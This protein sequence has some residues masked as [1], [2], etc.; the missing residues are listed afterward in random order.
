MIPSGTQTLEAVS[1]HIRLLSAERKIYTMGRSKKRKRVWKC[2]SLVDQ[3]KRMTVCEP[4]RSTEAFTW[5]LSRW[6]RDSRP[7]QLS[8]GSCHV[9]ERW[10]WICRGEDPAIGSFLFLSVTLLVMLSVLSQGRNNISVTNNI[11]VK[12]APWGLWNIYL[13]VI[14]ITVSFFSCFSLW[15]Y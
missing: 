15:P 1:R 13:T 10:W 8:G 14:S 11:V 9:K 5:V 4:C 2:M 12:Y 7:W 3:E 6:L